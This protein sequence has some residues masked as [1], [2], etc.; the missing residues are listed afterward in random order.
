MHLLYAQGHATTK[1]IIGSDPKSY[2][3]LDFIPVLVV[4]TCKYKADLYKKIKSLS[5]GR[6]FLHNKSVGD[7]SCRDNQ[8][9]GQISPKSNAAFLQNYDATIGQLA[10]E[11]CL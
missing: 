9:F 3:S 2:I 11:I 4:V 8:S 1:L 6:D 7:I 10:L 5:S